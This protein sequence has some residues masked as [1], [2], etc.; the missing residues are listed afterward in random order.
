MKHAR[1]DTNYP[2]LTKRVK[3][4]HEKT[5]CGCNTG[6]TDLSL[7]ANNLDCSSPFLLFN[8]RNINTD[9]GRNLK[10]KQD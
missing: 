7:T 5:S 1:T 4:Q 2:I 9:K 6:F 10:G 8:I 3:L